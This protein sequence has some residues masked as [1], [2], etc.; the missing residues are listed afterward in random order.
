ME[1]LSI[2]ELA[3]W[4]EANMQAIAAKKIQFD[5]TRVYPLLDALHV[6]PAS[7]TTYFDMTQEQYYEQVSDHELNLVNGQKAKLADIKDRYMVNHV[8]GVLSDDNINFA[9]NHENAYPNGEYDVTQDLHVLTY[10]LEVVGAVATINVDLVTRDL[11]RDAVI[12]L[13]LAAQHIAA[14]QS[15]EDR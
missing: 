3:D 13:A 5:P 14:W 8:D 10:G 7:V 1:K 6:L 15:G 9:Y 12:S 11:S 4:L 2:S